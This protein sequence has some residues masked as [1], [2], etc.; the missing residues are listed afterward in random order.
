M[1]NVLELEGVSVKARFCFACTWWEN[2]PSPARSRTDLEMGYR[3]PTNFIGLTESPSEANSLPSASNTLSSRSVQI[4]CLFVMEGTCH[5][6]LWSSS[7]RE[8]VGTL[9]TRGWEG[10]VLGNRSHFFRLIHSRI[11]DYYCISNDYSCHWTISGR[12]NKSQDHQ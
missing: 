11:K 6:S 7:W 1:S 3:R 12:E 5:A 10:K 8:V 9:M 2:R 4:S